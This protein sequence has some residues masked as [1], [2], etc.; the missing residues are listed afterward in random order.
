MAMVMVMEAIVTTVTIVTT[1][2]QR[3]RVNVT[4][5]VMVAG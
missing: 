5:A 4:V 3:L 2:L 1:F